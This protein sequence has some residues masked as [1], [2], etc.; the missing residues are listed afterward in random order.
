MFLLKNFN[1][2]G[3]VVLV[4]LISLVFTEPEK[5]SHK[6]CGSQFCCQN[7]NVVK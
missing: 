2:N 4:Y 1:L 7:Q 3:S 5:A 6:K